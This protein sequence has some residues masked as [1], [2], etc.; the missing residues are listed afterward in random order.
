MKLIPILFKPEMVRAILDDHKT[1][2]RRLTGLTEINKDPDAWSMSWLGFAI[3]E[4]GRLCFQFLHSKQ[5]KRPTYNVSCPYGNIGDVLW[6]RE[7]F[8]YR[9]K[10]GKYYYKADSL[11]P[12][13]E[14]YA[15]NGWKPG[16]HMPFT[17]CRIFL[18]IKNIKVE[19]LKQISELDAIAEGI[20][21]WKDADEYFDYLRT[22]PDKE[23][24]M[25]VEKEQSLKRAMA[26]HVLYR[27]YVHSV[28]VPHSVAATTS[29]QSSFIGLFHSVNKPKHTDLNSPLNNPWVWAPEFEVIS[30][31]GNPD[32]E[33]YALAKKFEKYSAKSSKNIPI[34]HGPLFEQESKKNNLGQ[35]Y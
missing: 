9:D 12:Y 5:S 16:I 20:Y 7:T 21:R 13:T 1:Q 30:K 24:G 10:Q 4:K 35:H 29:A 34:G 31:T 27:E 23:A 19:R 6:V 32:P 14:P 22:L 26:G 15:H 25:L 3:D 11:E 28:W 8:V 33:L 2:T 17:T 18:R